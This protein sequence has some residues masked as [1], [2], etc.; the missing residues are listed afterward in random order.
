MICSIERKAA[1]EKDL[2]HLWNDDKMQVKPTAS[3]ARSARLDEGTD[4]L[5]ARARRQAKV[6]FKSFISDQGDTA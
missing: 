1:E 5:T 6:V 2:W 3:S 4:V